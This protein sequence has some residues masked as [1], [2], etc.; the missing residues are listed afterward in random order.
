MG[1]QNVSESTF[2]VIIDNAIVFDPVHCTL[3]V[4][5]ICKDLYV[6]HGS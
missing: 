6:V 3:N 5:G 1:M 4:P 2:T